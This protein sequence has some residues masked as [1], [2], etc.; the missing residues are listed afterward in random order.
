VFFGD[1][2]K[3]LFRRFIRAGTVICGKMPRFQ[4]CNNTRAK[5]RVPF[6]NK[7]PFH[8]TLLYVALYAKVPYPVCL[9]SRL[10]DKR[11]ARHNGL[12]TNHSRRN[13][14]LANAL[15]A[16]FWGFSFISIKIA[17]PVFPPMVLG[18]LRFAIALVP[19]FALYRFTGGEPLCAADLPCLAGSGLAGVTFYFYFENNGVALV[20]ASE[21]SI[22]V[23]AIPVLS[24]LAEWAAAR[25]FPHKADGTFQLSWKQWLGALVS[26]AGVAFVAGVSFA[27]SG[28][29]SGYI[30]M[31][32]E[33]F[34]WVAYGFLTRPLFDRGRSRSYI[35]FWQNAFGFAGFLPFAA[36]EIPRIGTPD[37]PVMAH[38][39]FLA[40]CCSA[41]GY[42]L[43][44]H[45]L[46]VLGI[47]VSA[48]FINL[49]PV[50]TVI[51]GFFILDERLTALQWGGAALVLG[52]VYLTTAL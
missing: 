22:I 25:F 23:A 27:V 20:T 32:G 33:A 16:L 41:L 5:F 7:I 50:V 14:A 49:I 39:L 30:F 4:R 42:W 2:A 43:Y 52:G 9:I 12:M 17:V 37:L 3:D 26:A 36:L 11:A 47:S 34:C 35:V 19:L 29:A 46:K 1:K 13:A 31:G 18:A 45:A 6:I 15:C 10:P 21:A 44:A 51:A 24:M 40:L 38:V 28:S 48:V 8:F